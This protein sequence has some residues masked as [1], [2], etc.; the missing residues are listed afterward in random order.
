MSPIEINEVMV[1]G[2]A[3]R[4]IEEA[5]RHLMGWL[6]DGLMFSPAVENAVIWYPS[7]ESRSH[8]VALAVE[9]A[10]QS[11]VYTLSVKYREGNKVVEDLYFGAMVQSR[12]ARAGETWT[13]GRDL[14][15]GKFT[16]ACWH[17]IL[18]DILS[19]ELVKHQSNEWKGR[20]ALSPLVTD[21]NPNTPS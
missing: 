21:S 3:P 1:D 4:L 19:C 17:R 13:R 7:P 10:T 12:R 18:I 6:D 16:V 9:I 5:Y 8:D 15:D 14:H 2:G 11:Q 20:Y